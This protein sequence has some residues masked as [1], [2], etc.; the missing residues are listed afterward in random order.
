MYKTTTVLLLRFIASLFF[1]GCSQA[2]LA[3]WD[4]DKVENATDDERNITEE[5]IKQL[6]RKLLGVGENESEKNIRQARNKLVLVYGVDRGFPKEIQAGL[7]ETCKI[8]IDKEKP[9]HLGSTK[10]V[11]HKA[12]KEL[13]KARSESK[14]KNF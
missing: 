14:T 10:E 2:R 11:L 6:C 1:T 8:L 3:D 5:E 9:G 13:R 12:I 4:D 7:N